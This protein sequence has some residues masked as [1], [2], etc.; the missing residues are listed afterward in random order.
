M[1][2]EKR[3]YFVS[4]KELHSGA[5]PESNIWIRGY[6][7][8]MFSISR[9]LRL[10]RISPNGF[11]VISGAASI[12]GYTYFTRHDSLLGIVVVAFI[13]LLLDGVDGSLAILQNR[14]SRFGAVLDSVN[15]RIQE[16]LLLIALSWVLFT[17]GFSLWITTALLLSLLATLLLEYAR[18]RAMTKVKITIWERP[19]RVLVVTAFVLAA[20]LL[21]AFGAE[22]LYVMSSITMALSWVG[23]YQQFQ[24]SKRQLL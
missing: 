11:T 20:L 7:N 2:N 5:N 13:G 21:E 16:S 4:W 3:A 12:V 9:A 17:T 6:L 19:T 18:S 15:D 24:D 10:L 1:S 23:L 22:L 8:V 14:A